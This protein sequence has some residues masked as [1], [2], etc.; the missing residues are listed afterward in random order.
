M[1]ADILIKVRFKTEIEGGRKGAITGSFYGCPLF[2]DGSGFDCRLFLDSK[3]ELGLTYEVPV[4]FMNPEL[5]LPKLY[6]GKIFTLW[7]GKDVATGTV[8]KIL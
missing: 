8:L 4:K 3:I 5:V 2:V 7:E 1:K 6:P